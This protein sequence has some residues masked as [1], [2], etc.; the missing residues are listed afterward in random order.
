MA[1]VLS[2]HTP[3]IVP[4]MIGTNIRHV[5]SAAMVNNKMTVDL[6]LTGGGVLSLFVAAS[7]ITYIL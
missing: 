5:V 2:A 6:S 3:P 4:P 7:L 1:N